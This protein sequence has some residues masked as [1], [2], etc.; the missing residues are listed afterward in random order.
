[1]SADNKTSFTRLEEKHK[2]VDMLLSEKWWKKIVELSHTDRDI[3]IQLRSHYINVYSKMGNLLKISLQGQEICC[4]IHYKYL[5]APRKPEYVK[6]TPV[7]GVLKVM[8]IDGDPKNKGNICPNVEDILQSQNLKTIKANIAVYAGEE[9]AIQ[10]RLV[11]KNKETIIDVEV[12]FSG[13]S[14]SEE[15]GGDKGENARIDIVNVNSDEKHP[16]LVFVE[17]KQIFNTELY[18]EKINKQI[19]K[20]YDFAKDNKGQII[21][22]YREAIKTKKKLG[23]IKDKS[24]LADVEIT[25]IEPKPLLVVAG[26]N[27]KVIDGLREEIKKTLET[28]YL[29]GLY[30][31]GK[32]VDLNLTKNTNKEL[33][34]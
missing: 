32:D 33:F 30:F 15:V 17:L 5:I 3:N 11:E 28:K 6:I 16:K 4:E 31:F 8:P 19:K 26:F 13:M 12:A 7:N 27:Q 14:Q 34:L 10:S 18:G 23:I 25:A 29:A 2:L 9:K 24:F 1:M 22:A 20:Y 21:N